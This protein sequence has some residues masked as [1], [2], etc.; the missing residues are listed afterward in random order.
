MAQSGPEALPEFGWV[1][2]G[3]AE[4]LTLDNMRTFGWWPAEGWPDLLA[5]HEAAEREREK[6]EAY[7]DEADPLYFKAMRGEGSLAEWL[8]KV[9]EIKARYA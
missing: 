4:R 6:L 5:A 7:R 3:R 2:P 1:S 9:N 8:A